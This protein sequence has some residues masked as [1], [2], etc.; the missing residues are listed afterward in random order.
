MTLLAIFCYSNSNFTLPKQVHRAKSMPVLPVGA[1]SSSRLVIPVH[2]TAS[3][4]LEAEGFLGAVVQPGRRGA[5]PAYLQG[6]QANV[7]SNVPAH[8]RLYQVKPSHTHAFSLVYSLGTPHRHM[9][10]RTQAVMARSKRFCGLGRGQCAL[11]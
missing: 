8:L 7:T 4:N 1:G 11:C 6:L 3:G 9:W 5:T 2:T 10:Y